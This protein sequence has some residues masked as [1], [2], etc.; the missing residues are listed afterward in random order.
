MPVVSVVT[1]ALLSRKAYLR[2]CEA[3]VRAQTFRDFEHLIGYDTQRKGCARTINRVARKARGEWLFVLADDDL[4]LPGCLQTHLDASE[5]ADVVYAPPL[6]WGEDP[7]QFHRT[8][9]GI[10]AVALIRTE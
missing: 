7:V 6:V 1:P 4:L 3:S 9:P 10:P 5:D 8:P 2:E